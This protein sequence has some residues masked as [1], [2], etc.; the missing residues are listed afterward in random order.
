MNFRALI[1]GFAL[2]IS[3][4]L[5]AETNYFLLAPYPDARSLDR[6]RLAGTAVIPLTVPEHIAHARDLIQR[7]PL[8]DGEPN[9]PIVGGHVRAG[10]DGI[11]RNY[12]DP[13]LPEWSWNV[14]EVY[15]FSDIIGGPSAA[16]PA[17]LEQVITGN[18]AAWNEKCPVSFF[19]LTVVR[20]L[21]H[22]PIFL[23]IIGRNNALDLSWSAP[24]TNGISFTLESTGSLSHP[25]WHSV[26]GAS[27]LTANHC[28]VKC[29][30]T[31]RFYRV[32]AGKD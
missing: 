14:Y 24:V 21:G 7:G 32:R 27:F 19:G 4:S 17:S 15:G 18:P 3:S 26:S 20:E 25:A 30:G 5:F 31:N 28:T 12:F 6:D 10:K 13:E 29:S 11:N 16:S 8:I 23:S 9:A 22:N 1:A 2:A